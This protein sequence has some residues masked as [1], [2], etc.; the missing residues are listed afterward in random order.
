M[1]PLR[2]ENSIYEI[3]GQKVML[4]F[5]LAELYEVETKRINEAVKRNIER[6]PQKYMFRLTIVEW[7]NMRSQIATA[8]SQVKR[9]ERI[10]PYAFTEH[11]VTMLASVLK[12]AKA[13]QVNL[14]IVDAFIALR[15]F[16]INFKEIAD[17][18]KEL[19]NR[20]NKQFKDVYD[21]LDYLVTEKQETEDYKNRKR[22][23]FKAKK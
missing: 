4:D 16:A 14:A 21:A 15:Q 19:E 23:G 5:D 22:I 17:K 9:N 11:G 7:K 2:I 3:R 6:F 13:I 1:H 18:L 10:T 12:S 20:Y 8:S